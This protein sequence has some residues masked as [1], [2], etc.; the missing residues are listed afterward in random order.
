[1]TENERNEQEISNDERFV[2]IHSCGGNIVTDG[3]CT[4]CK[5]CMQ[6]FCGCA[7]G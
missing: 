7:C 4:W 3:K 5:K 6:Y 2:E 1:M